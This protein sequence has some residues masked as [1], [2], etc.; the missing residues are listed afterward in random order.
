MTNDKIVRTVSVT[1]PGQTSLNEE[2]PNAQLWM[3]PRLLYS[4]STDQF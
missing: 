2:N 4:E 1:I 3:S